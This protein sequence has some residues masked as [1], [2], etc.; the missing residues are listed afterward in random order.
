MSRVAYSATKDVFI[1]DVKWNRFI[2]KM[3]EGARLNHIGSGDSE[4]RSWQSNAPSVRNLLELSQ[5]PNDVIVSFE[6]KVPNGGRIDCMLYGEGNNGLKNVIHIELKQWGNN[7]VSELYDT[8]VFK[9]DA[10]TGGSY[11]AV[12][13]PSQQVLNYQ[14]HLLNFVEELN[15]DDTNLEGLAYCYNYDS[16]ATPNALYANHYRAILD[17][18]R[19]YSGNEIEPLATR[20]HEL[21]CNGSGLEIF[22]R[23]TTSRIRQSKTLLDAAA[24]MFKGITEFSLLDDQITASETI[25][26]EVRKASKKKGKTVVIVK[27]GPGTGKTVIALH[28]LAQMAQEGRASNMYFTTRSKALRESL[29]ERLLS[30]PLQDGNK[31]NA[32]DLISNIFHF[33]PHY[34]E[35]SEVDLLLVDEAHRVQKSA[36]YMGDKFFE[37]T[38]LSQVTSLIYC[39]KVCVFFIDDKQAIKTDEIGNSDDIEAA[40]RNYAN[41]IADYANSDFYQ[42]I[43]KNKRSLSKAESD[44]AKL[45]AHPKPE[46]YGKI[47]KLDAKISELRREITKEDCIADVKTT[48]TTPI[49]I[50]QLELKSQ[51]RCNGSDN[52]LDWLDEV[53]YKPYDL[54]KTSFSN[55][56]Y[57]FQIFG[58]PQAL[59]D[60]IKSLDNPDGHPKQVARIAAGY[61]WRWSKRPTSNGD[62]VKDVKIGDFEMPWETNEGRA[63][64]PFRDMYAS[65]ADTWAI[66]PQGINQVGCI[67]SIQGFEIDYIGVILGPDIQY[68]S[69][70]DCLIG[71]VGNNVA[72]QSNDSIEYTRYIRNAYRVLMSR[73]KKGCFVYCCNPEVA[74]FLERCQRKQAEIVEMNTG[75]LMAAEEPSVRAIIID[76]YDFQQ[77]T[78]KSGYIPLYSVRAAC[79]YFEDGEVPEVEGWIDAS[80]HGFRPDPKKHF[81]VHAK[82]DSMQPKIHNGDLC[83][84]EWYQAGS[85]NGE[86]VL[87][88]CQE[89]DLDY[90]GMYTIKKYHSEK[91]ITEEGWYHSK[92]ELEPLNSDYEVIE[93]DLERNFKTI[94][95]FKCVLSS[96]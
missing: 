39:S 17:Q 49:N 69:A 80:G 82:G 22:N 12:C 95:I 83:V 59:Y 50:I 64:G 47:A 23:V 93:L 4:I 32:S 40:A 92:V 1:D 19:L 37:Q 53:L 70:S 87:T 36:N 90:G 54:V 72:V 8:G 43:Q 10:F 84:F 5:I 34:Y 46:N 76:D 38:Y 35:E 78:D 14:T 79:G 58:T 18:H 3:R 86:I 60:K 7:S 24:N 11:K 89:R 52:Y 62:L 16:N 44:R 26:A 42:K 13:H 56:E 45:A 88:Q 63:F 77:R 31:L 94:G 67:F 96:D 27:G 29:R 41:S 71:Q 30:I 75:V 57:D 68:D 73:G 85:R 20:I 25:F 28:V 48:L 2:P 65:S 15:A 66:E 61:C 9:V 81:V 33:K 91:V 74:A 55:Q 51:F 21:L 6:Y